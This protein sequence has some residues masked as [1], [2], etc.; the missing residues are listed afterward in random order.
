MVPAL[1]SLVHAPQLLRLGGEKRRGRGR[2]CRVP[3]I[4][5]PPPAPAR[6]PPSPS[7]PRLQPLVPCRASAP[8]PRRRPRV[9][10]SEAQS[11]PSRQREPVKRRRGRSGGGKL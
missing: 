2:G 4:P 5:Q 6:G 11:S 8:V 1:R 7:Q 3:R 10:E 9:G